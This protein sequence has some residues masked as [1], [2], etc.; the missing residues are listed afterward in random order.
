MNTG[1]ETAPVDEVQPPQV[2]DSTFSEQS[3][4]EA[5][6]TQQGEEAKPVEEAKTDDESESKRKP[7]AEKRIAQL[8]WQLKEQERQ[9]EQLRQQ[10]SQPQKPSEPSQERPTLESVG[11]DEAKYT[12]AMEQYLN[13]QI[14]SRI[15]ST[16]TAKQQEAS[17]KQQAETLQKQTD[18]FMRKG[19]E[20]ADDFAEVVAD[21][22]LPVTESMRD[23]L[24][25]V[26]DGPK[27]LYHLAQNPAEIFRI[28][29]LPPYAQAVEIGR[30]EARLSLPQPKQNS[31]APP[32]VRPL[33]A[34]GESVRKDPDKMTT[35][36][37][38]AWRQKQIKSN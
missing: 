12:D 26:D 19:I 24:F 16:L 32:P 23:A 5:A 36:E 25:S 15:D 8:T 7:G 11:Y 33:S 37:W 3:E 30:L 34:G 28:A 27:V 29:S 4:V 21:E 9:F 17:R 31:S 10:I 22:S 35:K 38:L 18:S 6:D 14:E 1:E 13:S 20:L 2:E